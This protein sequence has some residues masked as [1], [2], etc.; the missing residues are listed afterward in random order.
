MWIEIYLHVAT[1]FSWL[2]DPRR[3]C[4]CVCVCRRLLYRNI[5]DKSARAAVHAAHQIPNTG[6]NDWLSLLSYY[7]APLYLFFNWKIV[8]IF[9]YNIFDIE[10]YV[11]WRIWIVWLSSLIC[12]LSGYFLYFVKPEGRNFWGN[13][14]AYLECTTL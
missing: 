5:S 4:V 13:I 7:E 6:T 11:V 1:R 2:P 12:T 3:F 10:I 9:L 14:D 8:M